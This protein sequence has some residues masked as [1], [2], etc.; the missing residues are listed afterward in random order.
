MVKRLA[1][2]SACAMMLMPMLVA[3]QLKP[4]EKFLGTWKQVPAP[5][6][7]LKVE[8]EGSGIKVSFGCKED[9]SSCGSVVVANY[10]GKPYKASGNAN[11]EYSYQKTEQ[12]IEENGYLNGK[13]GFRAKWQL[14]PDG[15]TLTRT[16]H[17]IVPPSS[18]DI[19]YVEDRSGGPVSKDDPFI[20]FWKHNWDKSSANTI[21]FAAKGN[22]FTVT[23]PGGNA[24]ERNCDGKDH[25]S[26]TAVGFSHNCRFTDPYTYEV[27]FKQNEKVFVYMTRRISDDGKKMV[28]IN[29]NGEGKTTS[30][31]SFEKIE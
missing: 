12:T 19:T 7:I 20:G 25:Q 29:K 23:G 24:N 17:Y 8:S 4:W 14:S 21:T 3:Q 1:L 15:T 13:P 18:K 6:D 16:L 26:A 2:L 31:S 5:D 22:V 11:W 9:G 28:T 27:V 30:E 10:D